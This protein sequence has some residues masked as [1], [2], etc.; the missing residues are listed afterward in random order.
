M[1]KRS[2]NRKGNRTPRYD[3]LNKPSTTMRQPENEDESHKDDAPTPPQQP[4]QETLRRARVRKALKRNQSMA[5]IALEVDEELRKR[6]LGR[7]IIARECEQLGHFFAVIDIEVKGLEL[8]ES[9]EPLSLKLED[10]TLATEEYFEEQNKKATGRIPKGRRCPI[11]WNNYRG[12]GRRKSNWQ[13]GNSIYYS[14]C[15]NQCATQ[16]TTAISKQTRIVSVNSN[17]VDKAENEYEYFNERN[18]D[19]SAE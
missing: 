9:E 1:A 19:A 8:P 3:E 4:P 2:S 13:K 10:M 17:P 15:C 14:F 7:A 6:G 16:W 18:R 11:C 5:E 12:F